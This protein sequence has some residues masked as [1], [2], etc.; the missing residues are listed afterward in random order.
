[1]GTHT[2]FDRLVLY[3]GADRVPTFTVT[4]Q[5]TAS[6]RTD[7]AD[8]LVTLRGTSGVRVVVHDTVRAAGV[9]TGMRPLFPALREVRGIGDFEAVVSYGVG[10]LGPA[11]IRVSTLASPYRLVID[12]AWPDPA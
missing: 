10:V 1:V 4:P 2:G 3:F 9:G 8:Q 11:R 12:L 6:F 7:P 5:R